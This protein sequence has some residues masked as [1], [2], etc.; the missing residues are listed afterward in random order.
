MVKQS[1]SNKAVITNTLVDKMVKPNKSPRK[2]KEARINYN[3][4]WDTKCTG[5]FVRMSP[6]GG[7]SWYYYYTYLPT[8]TTYNYFIG[9]YPAIKTEAARREGTKLAGDV[10]SGGNPHKDRRADIKSGTVAEYSEQYIKT[11]PAKKSRDR[12]IKMHRLYIQPSIGKLKLKNV[13]PVDIETMKVKYEATPAQ[14]NHIK[15]YTHKFFAWCVANSRRTGV[16][17]NPA[18]GIK[19]YKMEPRQ[20]V[21]SDV[22]RAKMSKVLKEEVELYPVECYFL[23]LL[24]STGCRTV[25][26]FSR[27]WNDV[28]FESAQI[29]NIPTKTGRKTITLS[30]VSIELLVN[31]AKHTS[32]TNWLF[33][34]PVDEKNH[35]KNFRAFWYRVRDKIGLSKTVQ[36]RDMRHHFVTDKI[37]NEIDVA[38]VSAL[39]NHGN[40]ATTVKHYAQVLQAT[41][42]KALKDTSKR[43]KLL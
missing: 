23:A 17:S 42:L 32:D 7:K 14:S 26:L 13:D 19:Q 40:I 33:P 28:D 22:V 10:A 15:V 43:D 8:S 30:K 11:L 18:A 12:E 1:I 6:S 29:F 34:S 9:K 20:F 38:T 3:V 36:M 4:L 24:V 16:I 21:M 5:L 37:N 25:E 31:L 35:R 2:G 27:P 39:V 41:K